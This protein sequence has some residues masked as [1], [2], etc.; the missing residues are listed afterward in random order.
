MKKRVAVILN[1]ENEILLLQRIRH[2][3]EYWVIPGGG[4]ENGES[5]TECAIRELKEE[6]ECEVHDN[7]LVFFV[8]WKTRE[9]KKHIIGVI[10]QKNIL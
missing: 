2:G 8:S 6:L 10:S 5:L 3:A 9:E 7:Q 1:A 4:M